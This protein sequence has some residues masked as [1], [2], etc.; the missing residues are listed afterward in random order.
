MALPS[1]TFIPVK[2]SQVTGLLAREGD[3]ILSGEKLLFPSPASGRGKRTFLL[4]HVLS[5]VLS[6]ALLVAATVMVMDDTS[7]KD[8]DASFIIATIA[9]VL[10]V[11][12]ILGIS[13]MSTTPFS[14]HGL[15]HAAVLFCFVAAVALTSVG[16]A[17][18]YQ[19]NDH[20]S[21]AVTIAF[22]SVVSQAWGIALVFAAYITGIAATAEIALPPAV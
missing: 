21:S 11:V 2:Q 15:M 17:V 9:F 13:A 14:Q 4:V 7:S 18:T 5:H 20:D 16:L 6:L 12:L 8:V 22:C 1:A 3:T 10:G 19:H